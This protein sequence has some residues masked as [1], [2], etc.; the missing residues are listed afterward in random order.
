MVEMTLYGRGGQGGVT[1]AKLIATAYFL[2]GKYSQ[3]F[4]LYAA[5]RSGAPIQAF[6]RV[7][8]DEITNHNQI[9]T[10]DHVI[11]LDPTLIAPPILNGLSLEGWIILNTPEPPSAWHKVFPGRR[12]ATIDATGIA[13]ENGLGTRAVPI[14]NTTMMGAI[15]RVFGM[16][17]DEVQEAFEHLKFGGANLIA[18]KE[19]YDRVATEQLPGDAEMATAPPLPARVA[20]I[21]DE[22]VGGPPRIR[23]GSWATRKPDRRTLTPPCNH[24]CPA[25]N[26]VQRFVA[27]ASQNEYDEALSVLLETSPLPG[28]CGRVCPAPCM[29]ACNRNFFDEGVNVRELERYVA[30]HGAWPTPNQPWRLERVAVV[31]SGPAGI[32]ASYQLAK[33]GYHVSL[34]EASSELGGVLRNGIP[35][36]RLPREILDRELGFVLDH[37]VTAYSDS[38]INR[39]ALVGLTQR[40]SAVFVATGLQRSRGLDLGAPEMVMQG[41]EFL[42]HV[43]NS[44]VSL[45]GERVIVVGGGNTAIDAARSALRLGAKE[46]KILYRRSRAEMPAIAEEI[47]A[48]IEEGVELHELALPERVLF[49]DEGTRILSC[50]RMILGDPDE[51]GRRQP[52]VDPSPDAQFTMP[53][54]RIILALGQSADL[55]ILN[56]GAEIRESG[57]LVGIVEAPVFVGGDLGTNEGTV[58]AAIGSGRRAAW[59]VHR[60]L[61]GEDLF[62]DAEMPVAT[63]DV[64]HM[65]SFT[66]AARKRGE[67]VPIE[68]RV[69]TFTEVHTGFGEA[70]G[71]EPAAAEAQRCFS[72][73]VCNT[74]DRCLTYCPEGILTRD[75]DGYRFNYDYCKGCGVCASECPRGVI[76]MAEL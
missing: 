2:R 31:G 10:P 72:C 39:Q 21:L 28:I 45:N 54:D 15:A 65:Q 43:H 14:V 20:G 61:T 27:A 55:S 11:V 57:E 53:C 8:D 33:L 13:V 62:P 23:T 35:E 26:D 5:E 38:F 49:E 32:S 63:Q 75:D 58:T 36:Y 76:I 52:M 16:T 68:A 66:H 40:Y 50:V 19:A 4:G 34:Y 69:H 73:G 6:V 22:D 64:L 67:A 24:T 70:A 47:D 71:D 1:L 41:I 17:F 25:G 42:D 3:A 46:V 60:A 29:D 51:S 9:R 59:H 30:D 44:E 12:V 48:A 18:A 7:D 37:G 74:C 56:E